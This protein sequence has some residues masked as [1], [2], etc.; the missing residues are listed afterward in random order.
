M[1]IMYVDIWEHIIVVILNLFWKV[2]YSSVHNKP[3]I[4]HNIHWIYKLLEWSVYMVAD[5]GHLRLKFP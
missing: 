3:N 4:T 2:S 5:H 1:G